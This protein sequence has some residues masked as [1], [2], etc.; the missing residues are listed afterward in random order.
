MAQAFST[1]NTGN[2]EA[3]P[4]HRKARCPINEP[5]FAVPKY[6]SSTRPGSNPLLRT[7]SRTAPAA[8]KSALTSASLEKGTIPVA[9]T[10]TSCMVAHSLCSHLVLA[11]LLRA[12][13]Q[14][15]IPGPTRTSTAQQNDAERFRVPSGLEERP[16]PN[17]GSYSL[18]EYRP[19]ES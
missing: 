13:G 3:M 11:S 19:R 15:K 9:T 2:P 1:L 16:L 8:S 18:A 7:R 10:I 4:V 6:A 12:D 14:G 17:P 5:P